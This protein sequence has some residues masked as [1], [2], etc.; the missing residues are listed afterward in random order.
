[1]KWDGPFTLTF[2][3][4]QVYR[5]WRLS[6]H[7][8]DLSFPFSHKPFFL[9][10]WK[11]AAANRVLCQDSW[12]PEKR[13]LIQGQRRGLITSSF[14]CSKVLLQFNRD[15]ESFW[16]RHQKGTERVPPCLFLARHFMSVSKLLIRWETPQGWGSFHQASLPQYV[17]LRLDGMKCVLLWP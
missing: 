3:L 1:M 6:N 17:F 15:R 7:S 4:A 5:H 8:L 16:H 2:N 14:L 9:F 12:P 11:V 13:I 10:I